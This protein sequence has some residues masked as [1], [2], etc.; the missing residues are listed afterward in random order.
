M[1]L[2]GW[3]LERDESPRDGA[4]QMARDAA[5]AEWSGAHGQPALRLYRWSRAC[6]TLGRHESARRKFDPAT[7]A[8]LGAEVVRRPT[9]GRA[10]WHAHDLTYAFAAPASSPA[11][12]RAW[13][14][15]VHGVLARALQRLGFA[16]ELAPAARAATLRD[17]ACFDAAVG[18]EVLVDG[19]KVAGSAQRLAAGVL[20]QQGTVLLSGAEDQRWR[21]ARAR[22]RQCEP[23]PRQAN[24]ALGGWDAA[25]DA[26]VHAF[27]ALGGPPLPLP[28]LALD[29]L[30]AAHRPS[31]ADP[32]WTW[33]R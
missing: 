25:A 33:Q 17:G 5:L 22:G 27:T 8:E 4:S 7:L 15:L 9:G 3:R 13:F 20:L 19:A 26:V 21:I 23:Y 29:A 2:A 24:Q 1:T 31:Y 18:G 16:A 11:E 6:V 14:A 28:A 32:G 10:V 30:A 12:A